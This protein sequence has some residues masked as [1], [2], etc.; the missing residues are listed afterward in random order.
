M[1]NVKVNGHK[2]NADV[3]AAF[4]SES[5]F[6]K[7][8]PAYFEGVSAE[9]NATDL[10]LVYKLCCEATGKTTEVKESKTSPSGK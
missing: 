5:D 7:A 1:A 2:F 6:V 9:Q 3:V 8:H 4:K 10:K